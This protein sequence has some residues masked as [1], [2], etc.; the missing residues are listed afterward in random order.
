[1]YRLH[2]RDSLRNPRAT[3]GKSSVANASRLRTNCR[4]LFGCAPGGN[5]DHSGERPMAACA[6]IAAVAG[7]RLR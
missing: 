3:P 7:E 1:M 4:T 5:K 6:G 2:F